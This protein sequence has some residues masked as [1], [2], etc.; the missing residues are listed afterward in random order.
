[1]SLLRDE[2]DALPSG[3]VGVCMG[4]D[5]GWVDHLWGAVVGVGEGGEGGGPAEGGREGRQTAA[6]SKRWAELKSCLMGWAIGVWVF[7]LVVKIIG[8]IVETVKSL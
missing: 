5:G 2:G 6:R 8:V 7:V 1:M 4:G 3:E